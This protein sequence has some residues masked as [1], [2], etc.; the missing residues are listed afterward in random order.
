MPCA[1]HVCPLPKVRACMQHSDTGGRGERGLSSTVGSK[2]ARA[3]LQVQATA[4]MHRA[5]ENNNVLTSQHGRTTLLSP[6]RCMWQ[7]AGVEKRGRAG[8]AMREFE[9]GPPSNE[10]A[11]QMALAVAAVRRQRQRHEP[12]KPAQTVS[13]SASRLLPSPPQAVQ[14]EGS[15]DMMVPAPPEKK[16]EGEEHLGRPCAPPRQ[17]LTQRSTGSEIPST[18]Q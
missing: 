7:S 15:H 13:H 1:T 11:I 12:H 16:G 8:A 2:A 18:L 5:V 3:P 10:A 9:G 4:R 17:P 6:P 14:S